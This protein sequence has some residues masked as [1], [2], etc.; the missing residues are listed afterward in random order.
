MILTQNLELV[1]QMLGKFLKGKE[2]QNVI[3]IITIGPIKIDST[4]PAPAAHPT[5]PVPIK[6][7]EPILQSEPVPIKLAQ[8]I[9]PAARMI[10]DLP[11]EIATAPRLYGNTLL[12]RQRPII[13]QALAACDWSQKRAADQLGMSQRRMN[14]AVKRLGITHPNWRKN[15]GIEA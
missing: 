14:Y 6:I 13:E 7:A 3:N 1:Q 11:A 15:N 8:P 2:G 10:A 4:A 5:G 9:P 12:E